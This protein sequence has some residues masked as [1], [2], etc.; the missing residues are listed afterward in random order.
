MSQIELKDEYLDYVVSL[1]RQL[2]NVKDMAHEY[3][4]RVEGLIH[5]KAR[6]QEE[7]EEKNKYI[8]RLEKLLNQT[9]ERNVLTSN[10][11]ERS[12]SKIRGT[13]QDVNINGSKKNYQCQVV[14]SKHNQVMRMK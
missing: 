12:N 1:Q 7:V 4:N 5:E 3:K 14:T 9:E 11:H 8:S 13:N 10:F 2:M 6:Y